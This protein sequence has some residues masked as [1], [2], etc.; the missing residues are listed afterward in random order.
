MAL[1]GVSEG[2]P[3]RQGHLLL[4][5]MWIGLMRHLAQT[6]GQVPCQSFGWLL[7]FPQALSWSWKV[8]F[9]FEVIICQYCFPICDGVLQGL[10]L[11]GPCAGVHSWGAPEYSGKIVSRWQGSSPFGFHMCSP[12]SSSV[13]PWRGTGPDCL[14]CQLGG[15]LPLIL[16]W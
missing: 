14:Y 15:L 5:F 7:V 3:R 11:C 12:L 6:Q 10:I 1:P 8:R 13:L 4:S 9:F 2:S 16:G